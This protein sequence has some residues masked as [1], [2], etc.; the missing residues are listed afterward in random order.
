MA[1]KLKKRICVF[2]SLLLLLGT[3][4]SYMSYAVDDEPEY[5]PRKFIYNESR[6][7]Y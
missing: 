3:A 5:I 7:G 6:K 2:L 1:K 4:F